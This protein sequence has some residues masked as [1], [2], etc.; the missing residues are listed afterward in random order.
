MVTLETSCYH[1]PNVFSWRHTRWLGVHERVVGRCGG[2]VPPCAG[3]VFSPAD[4]G[5][6]T[7]DP[8]EPDPATTSPIHPIRTTALKAVRVSGR[9]P[10]QWFISASGTLLQPHKGLGW[11]D[12]CIFKSTLITH[13]TRLWYQ[14]GSLL[15]RWITQVSCWVCDVL[16]FTSGKIL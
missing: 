4:D 11:E 8:G 12:I 7:V 2:G 5:L 1:F 15:L 10:M 14:S 13:L 6:Q 16:Q 9:S 3:A